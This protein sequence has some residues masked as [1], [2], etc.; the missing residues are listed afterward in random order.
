MTVARKSIPPSPKLTHL[1]VTVFVLLLF[2]IFAVYDS[3]VSYSQNL[4]DSPYR[5]TLLHLGWVVLG[6]IGFLIFNS[7]HYKTW[8]KW[9]R[10]LFVITLIFLF[11]LAVFG[12]LTFQLKLLKCDSQR[13][14]VPCINGSY[15]WLHLNSQPLPQLPLLG[16]LSFQPSELAKLSLIIFISALLSL[17]GL[18]VKNCNKDS[19]R[20]FLYFIASVSAIF[21][22]ILLQ[23]NMSTA[24]LT[25]FISLGIYFGS[26]ASL[27]P[28]FIIL[29]FAVLLLVFVILISPYRRQR[30]LTLVGKAESQEE[31]LSS[32]YHAHQILISLGSGGIFG[33][34]IGQSRQ[35][36]Q[37]LPEVASDSI[38]AIIG[39]ELGFVGVAL[40][41]AIYSYLI[42]QGFFIAAH[43]PDSFS[44][45]LAVGITVWIGGQFFINVASMAQLI[46]LTG[47]PIPLISYGGSSLIFALCGLGILSNI[48]KYSKGLD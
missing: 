4:Y 43:A 26:D 45:N 42:Y 11:I 27:K 2:G 5:F 18:T 33:L 10:P 29:P 8:I 47:V 21:F 9:S 6:L 20:T 39:E 14:F 36:Y 17:E 16:T 48:S 38:F 3:T 25:L 37:Y 35:K 22:L 46:P 7:V 28:L 23:P 30:L 15:R 24:S 13:P 12:F 40:F 41:I 34:G 19:K 44:K 31:S 32:G 1:A